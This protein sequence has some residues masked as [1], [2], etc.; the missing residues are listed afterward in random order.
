MQSTV[1]TDNTNEKKTPL[2][3]VN[4]ATLLIGGGIQVGLSFIEHASRLKSGQLDFIFVVSQALYDSL[5]VDLQNDKR[6]ILCPVSPA[7][8]LS[9]KKSRS[10]LKKIEN[11]YKPDII[12]SLGFPSYVR[13]ATVEIGKYTNPWEIN[14][15]P[16]PWHTLTFKQKVR[17]FLMI[18]YRLLWARRAKYFETQT[19]AA[20]IGIVKRLKVPGSCVKVIPNSPNPLFINE[21]S[22]VRQREPGE[23][24]HI[25]CLSAAYRHKNLDL[26]P[27]VALYLKTNN[28][29]NCKFILT[30]PKDGEINKEIEAAC[31]QLGV[32]DMVINTGPIK[33]Q[34]CLHWYKKA[35]AV[36]LPTLLE[37]FS[38]TYVE[39]MAMARPIVTTD[40]DFA[41]DVCGDAALYFKPADAVSAAEALIKLFN[42][43][44]LS[45]QLTER[46]RK[47]LA[48]FPNPEHKHQMIFDWLYSI[49]GNVP[50]VGY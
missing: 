37:V 23:I 42:D 8:I 2:I 49:A 17:M 5:S 41:H 18:Q 22:L 7:G 15:P 34:E 11:D 30:I 9:G 29:P 46:G 21:A 40:L 19:A 24:I 31:L 44:E 50:L 1:N 26:I 14:S 3:L 4:A 13:F 33:L 47:Q 28:F 16:L 39:A 25:F 12:Y 36:F 38:A 10:F 6:T 45:N 35:D 48:L 32:S 27:K 20:K 43:K